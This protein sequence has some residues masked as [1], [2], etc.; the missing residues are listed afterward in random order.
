M[1]S[2]LSE[3]TDPKAVERAIA[4]SDKLGRVEF[5]EKH[6]FGKARSYFLRYNGKSYDSKPIVAV[7]YGI[8][9]NTKPLAFNDFGGGDRTVKRTLERLGFTVVSTDE[10]AP[11]AFTS[12]W[13]TVGQVYTRN[14]LRDTF[15]I[16]DATSNNG[17][18]RPSGYRSI[19]LFV[20]RDKS[21]D[22]PQLHDDLDGDVLTWT[23][24]PSSRTDKLITDHLDDG[25][26]VLLF[27][28]QTARTFPNGGFRYEGPFLYRSHTGNKPTIFLL[29]RDKDSG[30]APPATNGDE[31]MFDPEN[32]ADGRS[33][34]LRAI[35]QRQGQ[36]KFR[37]DVLKAYG[38]RCAI[39]GCAIV[40]LLEAAHIHPY[41]GKE[42]HHVSNG[43]LLRAD[44][45]TLFDLGMIWIDDNRAVK[46]R[47]DLAGSGYEALG[48]LRLPTIAASKPSA[49]ALEWHRI[50]IAKQTK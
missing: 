47:S 49:K 1:A 40:E 35:H 16:T 7:A 37:K 43:L 11:P 30:N 5:R 20:T 27:Y 9:H 50:H 3:I 24:Q 39:S 22:R 26:E 46:S 14:N 8:E 28:R 45:H 21:A 31:N 38:N 15:V 19:W 6:G 2:Y 25:N 12:E 32:V 34:T 4:L 23:G 18:F 13:L 17:I 44:L 48:A 10:D 41:R 36:G 29:D 33:K 42:T